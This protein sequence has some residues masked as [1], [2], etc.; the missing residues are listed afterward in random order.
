MNSGNE[1]LKREQLETFVLRQNGRIQTAN[2][3]WRL[4][5]TRFADE[6]REVYQREILSFR[7]GADGETEVSLRSMRLA[8]EVLDPCWIR[9][10]GQRQHRWLNEWLATFN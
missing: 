7:Q 10:Y 5:T 4:I 2:D 8:M 9:G 6:I 1:W 3:L